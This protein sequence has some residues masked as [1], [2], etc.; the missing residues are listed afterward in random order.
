MERW[1]QELSAQGKKNRPGQ[2]TN[3][4][5]AWQ[6]NPKHKHDRQRSVPLARFERL[7]RVPGVRLFSLQVGPGVEQLRDL[8]DRFPVTDLGGQFDSASLEAA[9]AAVACSTW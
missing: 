9:A 7:A 3:V 6:G 5:I 4:G 8:G 1:R 2:S